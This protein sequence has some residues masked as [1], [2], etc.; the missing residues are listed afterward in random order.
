MATADLG[1]IE[2]CGLL[3]LSP[4]MDLLRAWIARFILASERA[5]ATELRLR[6][7]RDILL[8]HT[9]Q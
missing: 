8:H 1:A 6:L 5:E 2:I 3:S 4:L 7:E 9:R